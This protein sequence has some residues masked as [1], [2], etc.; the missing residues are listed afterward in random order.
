MHYIFYQN[1]SEKP[2]LIDTNY[3]WYGGA[4]TKG[5]NASRSVHVYPVLSYTSYTTWVG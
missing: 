5:G 3:P 4:G 1:V 2:E